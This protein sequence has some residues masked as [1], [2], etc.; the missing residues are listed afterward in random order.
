M[1]GN[2]SVTLEQICPLPG[3][4][5]IDQYEMN[6]RPTIDVLITSVWI[7]I[8]YVLDAVCLCIYEYMPAIDKSLSASYVHAGD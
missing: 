1:A 5:I 8:M 3:E 4:V 7:G 6:D 2:L